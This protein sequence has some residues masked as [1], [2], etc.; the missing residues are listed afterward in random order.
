VVCCTSAVGSESYRCVLVWVIKTPGGWLWVV[1]KIGGK[2][3]ERW[4]NAECQRRM[5]VGGGN[6]VNKDK[7]VH[8]WV[9]RD[10]KDQNVSKKVMTECSKTCSR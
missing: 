4:S 7:H 8:T 9:P 1:C 2:W 5:A 10:G 3:E 6:K